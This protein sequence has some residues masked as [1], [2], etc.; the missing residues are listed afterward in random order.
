MEIKIGLMKKILILILLGLGVL[1]LI[2]IYLSRPKQIKIIKPQTH[3]VLEDISFLSKSGAMLKGWYIQGKVNKAGILLMHGLHSNRLQMLNRAEILNEAG[4]SVVLFDFQGHG[5]SIGEKITFGHL[6]SLDAEAGLSYLKQRVGDNKVGVIGVSLGGASALLGA[7]KYKA[8][9]MILESV[10]PS[11]E[12]AINNR[13]QVKLGA[14]ARYLLPILTTQLNIQLGIHPN[15]L[16][17]IVNI[18]H[19]TAKLFIIGGEKDVR[20]IKEETEALYAKAN[21]PKKLWIVKDA[22]HIDFDRYV[23]EEYKKKILNFFLIY[24]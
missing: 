4:Y 11:I 6:E 19:A 21:S 22:N 23:P 17:P 9:A 3:L 18:S 15:Q 24:L 20:T 1:Y 8:D 7:V 16:Q 2:G 12:Q 14:W 13:L 10:Y 5:E